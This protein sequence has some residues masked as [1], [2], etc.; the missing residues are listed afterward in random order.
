MLSEVSLISTE[1]SKISFLIT[2][3]WLGVG[4]KGK[5]TAVKVVALLYL[6]SCLAGCHCSIPDVLESPTLKSLSHTTALKLNKGSMDKPLLLVLPQLEEEEEIFKPEKE[7]HWKEPLETQTHA[8]GMSNFKVH[9]E[10][11]SL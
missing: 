10:G 1:N 5:G 9:P 3:K 7:M 2:L 11:W 8:Q 4:R 6:A